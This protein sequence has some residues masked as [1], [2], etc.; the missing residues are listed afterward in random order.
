MHVIL[1]AVGDDRPGLT[2]SLADAIGEAEG[3]W[4]ESHFATLGGKFVGS[5][6]V[7]L[8]EHMVAQLEGAAG[9][10]AASG[11]QV[12][13][14]PAAAATPVGS[15]ALSFELVG[16]DRPGIVRELSTALARLGVSIDDLVTE[17]EEGAMFGGAI[18]RA[19]VR[20]AVPDGVSVDEVQTA[21][22]DISG[23]I[24]VDF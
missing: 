17:T 15:K 14:L 16:A 1:M 18:F 21:L 6:L 10:M 22:E 8:P 19:K 4:L 7:E 24:M 2:K 11:F 12:S 3:N 23:E 20:V 9:T 13:V 5:V